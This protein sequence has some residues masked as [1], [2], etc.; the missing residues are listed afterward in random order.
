[1]SEQERKVCLAWWLSQPLEAVPQFNK[2]LF[3]WQAAQKEQD[4]QIVRLE[5][6][7]KSEANIIEKQAAEL[8]T[9]RGFAQAVTGAESEKR[10]YVGNVAVWVG[11]HFGL[12]DENGNPTPLLTGVKE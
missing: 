5:N 2:A 1:M 3:V 6:I 7:V 4:A 8:A 12:Y 11:V 9:L 10:L